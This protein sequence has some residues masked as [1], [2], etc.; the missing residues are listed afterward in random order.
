MFT[1]KRRMFIA[2]L[3]IAALMTSGVVTFA[4]SSNVTIRSYNAPSSIK[5]GKGYSVKGTISSSTKI[6]RVEIGIVKSS[7]G[8]TKYK[9]DNKK[10]NAK[11]FNVK[12]ADS[13]L[14]F[15][16]LSTGTYY[17][18]IYAHTSDG[19]CHTVLNQKFSVTASTKSNGASLKNM[20][21]PGTLVKGKGFNVKGTVKSS[22]KIKSVTV[23]VTNA[24]GSWTNV[25]YTK[26]K[27]NSKSYNLNKLN[28]KIIFG[29][30]PAG[31]Y[32]YRVD[33]TT[34]K[35]TSTL[36]NQ[37]FS[38]SAPAAAAPAPAMGSGV[39]STEGGAIASTNTTTD[40]SASL[41]Q[42]TTGTVKVENHNLPSN[43]S[44]GKSFA[45]KG[46]IQS[47]ETI[48]RVEVGIIFAPTNKW[49]SYKYDLSGANSNTFDL[50]RAASALKF[51]KLPGGTF[52]YR[53]YVHTASGVTV[54]L[55]HPFTVAP[56]NKPTAA[57]NWAIK[58][59]NDD[60]FTYGAK[61]AT[62]KLGCYFC[63]TNQKKKPKGYEKTYVCL[64]FVGAAYA[65]GA[66]DPE[67]HKAC[68]SAKMP[69]YENDY[70]FKKFSCWMKL[71]SCKELSVN[72]LQPG[73]VVIKWSDQNDNN[74]HVW[75]YVGGDKF[76]DS[77]GYGW[78]AK[79]I[80]VRNGASNL[81]K[82][83]GSASSKNYVMRYTK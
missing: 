22:K 64:T 59:A 49:T 83:Y 32:R 55:N 74:G 67:I 48:N 70:N 24:S 21:Y 17:Y 35:G 37:A 25:K 54:A 27:I 1:R 75:M 78:Q 3:V 20:S 31:S 42:T 29:K 36:A 5:A 71:G 51:E 62:S 41:T 33:V 43:Y 79:S 9:Y 68:A 45:I 14:K 30:L 63:G 13:K 73:D 10:V 57:V 65:H 11:S 26:T 82:K 58:I 81:L 66:N 6:K 50:S 69:M 61:P 2:L 46:T 12:K 23:G 8:W 16:K 47:E 77:E 53:I 52:K 44:V 4:A 40:S 18:R 60:S 72:D 56:S 39:I 15:G 80:A 38:V 28:S 34:T 19:V 76:V 7:G